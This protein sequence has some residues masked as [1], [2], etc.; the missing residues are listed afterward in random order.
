[1]EIS[2]DGIFLY[3]RVQHNN[4]NKMQEI[5]KDVEKLLKD[6]PEYSPE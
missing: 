3:D 1:M 5:R 4:N 2:F 6:K